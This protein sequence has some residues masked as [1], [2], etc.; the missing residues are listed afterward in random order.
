MLLVPN[1]L[2]PAS[3]NSTI[4]KSPFCGTRKVQNQPFAMYKP[5]EKNKKE[6][7]RQDDRDQFTQD[8]NK[9]KIKLKPLEKNKYRLKGYD[10]GSDEE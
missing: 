4:R 6:V 3:F 9:K 7:R 1:N 10:V 5:W 2:Q 8:N